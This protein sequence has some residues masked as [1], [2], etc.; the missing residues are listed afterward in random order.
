MQGCVLSLCNISLELI[1]ATAL[2]DEEVGIQRSAVSI[3]NL[4]FLND[5]ALLVESPNELQAIVN[6]F[7]LVAFFTTPK[8][9]Q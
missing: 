3:N 8:P 2:E 7:F 9:K 4:C 5:T 1:T 6:N